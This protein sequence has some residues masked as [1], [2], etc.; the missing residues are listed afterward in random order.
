VTRAFKKPIF[1]PNAARDGVQNRQNLPVKRLPDNTVIRRGKVNN[2]RDKNETFRAFMMQSPAA[3]LEQ[4]AA[5]ERLT[6][7]NFIP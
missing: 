2:Q 5:V 3:E 1:K 6:Q 7:A 4:D